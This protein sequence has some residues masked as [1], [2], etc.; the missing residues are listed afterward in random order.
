MNEL[1]KY[2]NKPQLEK[3][4]SL[5]QSEF[6][7]SD[8]TKDLTEFNLNTISLLITTRIIHGEIDNELMFLIIMQYI[9]SFSD[10][11]NIDDILKTIESRSHYYKDTDYTLN[12]LAYLLLDSLIRKEFSAQLL[13]KFAYKGLECKILE[14]K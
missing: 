4:K 14:N 9:I 13:L 5:I 1:H 12:E 7:K 11:F 3:L 8:N 10:K 2:L 6:K